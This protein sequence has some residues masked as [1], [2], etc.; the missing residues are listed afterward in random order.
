MI[1]LALITISGKRSVLFN[2]SAGT[3]TIEGEKS[4]DRH[5][6]ALLVPLVDLACLDLTCL[7][8][9]QLGILAQIAGSWREVL[10]IL[11]VACNP[12]EPPRLLRLL[13]RPTQ[14]TSCH[15]IGADPQRDKCIDTTPTGPKQPVNMQ[16]AP[17]VPSSSQVVK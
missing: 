5:A 17:G 13:L 10:H 11:E 8:P 9:L 15:P 4:H 12:T 2:V 14:P 16:D 3:T 7:A 6:V 1:L